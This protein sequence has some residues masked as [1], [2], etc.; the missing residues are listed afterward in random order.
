MRT[1]DLQS[2]RKSWIFLA[3]ILTLVLCPLPLASIYQW[4][5]AGIAV[6]VGVLLLLWCIRVA[7]NPDYMAFAPGRL[8]FPGLLFLLSV[9]WIA[10]QGTGLT[11]ASWHH[12]IWIT[13]AETLGA[14]AASKISLDPYDT[15]SGLLQLL[16]CAGVF[17]LS[18][19]YCS[20]RERART[21]L[22][23]LGIAGALYAVYG[24]V[25]EL[26]GSGMILW[27]EK[28]AYIGNVTSTFVNRNMYAV[29]A[30]FG[31]LCVAG[32]LL[33]RCLLAL[34]RSATVSEAL[35][36]LIR[37]APNQTFALS[38]MAA[39]LLVAIGFTESRGG[40]ISAAAALGILFVCLAS[41]NTSAGR[42]PLLWLVGGFVTTSILV[43][44][45]TGAH[46]GG[47]FETQ[48]FDPGG[49]LDAYK[50]TL[51]AIQ[52]APLRGFGYGTFLEIFYLYSD[53]SSW[54]NL[55]YSHNLYL[56]AAVELGIPV[57]AAL[58][59]AVAAVVYSC[60]RGLRR[61][62]R[63]RVFPALGVA[64]TTLIA[65]H[66]LVDSPLFVPANAV[67][68]SFLL[69]LAYAQSWSIRDLPASVRS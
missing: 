66:G 13:A 38:A 1:S 30:G 35:G 61:R 8:W 10:I 69:G 17:W 41:R 11:P 6:I 36:S 4:S 28:T 59:G 47:R 23:I 15:H 21:A 7:L 51:S 60:L 45:V 3:L 46:L 16:T 44:A 34:E 42:R 27:F 14:K 12:P 20:V 25:A 63:D 33:E 55:N 54:L 22:W 19:Q 48:F 52:D 67:T 24:L 64:A 5:W 43:Y 37:E 62:K 68:Y 49:R 2:D 29:Y 57:A 40:A 32:L 31:F 18:V 65:V 53:G 56:G 50:M 9:S 26:S 39:V 58:I